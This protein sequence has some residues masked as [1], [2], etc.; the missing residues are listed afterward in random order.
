MTM[1]RRAL[2]AAMSALPFAAPAHAADATVRISTAAPPSDFLAKACEALKAQAEAS[3]TGLRVSVHP[4][5]TLFKQGTEVP[6]LQRGN[7]EMSTMTTFEVAQQMPEFGFLNRAYLF[8]DHAHLRAVFDGP[9]GTAYRKAVAEKM[10]LVILATAYLGTRHV[11]LAKKR[12]VT[13]PQDLA[14][15]KMRMPA[16]PDWLVLGRVLGVSPVPMGMPEVYLALKTGTIDGQE[17][18]LSVFNAAKLF[19]VSEQIVLTAHMLQPVFFSIA[20][21]FWDKLTP[22]QQA[23][24]TAA[25]IAAAKGNDDGRLADE[26]DIIGVMKAKGIAIDSPDLAPF[27]ALAD[28][29]YADDAGTK[30]WDATLAKQVLDTK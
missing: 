21:P 2:L 6:A 22:A 30:A 27:R 11:A 24:L 5:S 17:N 10:G 18:P 12:P 26:R 15:V 14:G 28:K 13:G 29:L 23:A 7:L 25:A 1:H 20:R 16:G 4:A 3:N 9:F 19:E 8:R